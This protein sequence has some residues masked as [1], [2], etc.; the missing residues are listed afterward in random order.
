M[1]IAGMKV[2]PVEIERALET[3]AGVLTCHVDAVPSSR[4]VEVIRARVLIRHDAQI[5]RAD[6]IE[7]CRQRLAEY[8]LPR[9]IEF[10][11][12]L[13]ATFAGKMPR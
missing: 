5:T 12:V 11:E 1:N 10:V 8:K 6:I 2:D 4:V 7:H 13:P 9:I 3:L